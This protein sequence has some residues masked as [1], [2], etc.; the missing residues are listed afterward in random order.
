MNTLKGVIWKTFLF[1][2]ISLLTPTL[3]FA[4]ENT[5]S[6]TAVT[7]NEEQKDRLINLGFSHEEIRTMSET[8]YKKFAD[9]NGV[10][11]SKETK[12]FEVIEEQNGDSEF[13]EVSKEQAMKG[14]LKSEI[15]SYATATQTNSWMRL[16]LTSSKLSNGNTLLKNNF[17]WQRQPNI[18]LKDVVGITHSANAVKVPNTQSFMYSYIDKGKLHSKGPDS[19]Q[20]S[21]VGTSAK[22]DLKVVGS[23]PTNHHGYLSFQVKK[24]NKNDVSANA[25][26]HYAHTTFGITGTIDLKTGSLSVGG[27]S[28]VSYAK[29][30]Y[31]L[32]NY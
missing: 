10:L 14:M 9:L 26:G 19:Y 4:S 8:E 24:G 32:F 7:L 23:P 30:P 22:Y 29:V 5:D 12:Y 11:T 31:I 20:H 27:A 25:Y 15:Q 1:V 28:K 21:A 18:G 17:S 16:T 2:G 3:V 6:V 13:I